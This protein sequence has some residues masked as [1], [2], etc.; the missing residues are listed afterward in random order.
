MHLLI[1][2]IGDK[3]KRTM[4]A[5]SYSRIT[6]IRFLVVH[7]GAWADIKNVKNRRLCDY[8]LAYIP[9]IIT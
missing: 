2:M 1:K 8:A 7:Q 4:N 3:L 6:S 5:L 9:T